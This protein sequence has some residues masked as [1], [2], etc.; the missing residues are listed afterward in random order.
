MKERWVSRGGF[1]GLLV[2]TIEQA[3]QVVLKESESE[4][5]SAVSD[6]F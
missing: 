6:S 1:L 3:S 4:S 2:L 5:C